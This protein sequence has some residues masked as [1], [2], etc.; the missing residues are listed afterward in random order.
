MTVTAPPRPS[1]PARP[2]DPQALIEEA[3]RRAR[4]RRRRTA[5]LLA[6]V[7]GAGIA[8]WLALGGGSIA[9]GSTAVPRRASATGPARNGPLTVIDSLGGPG[10]IYAVG[11]RGRGRRLFAGAPRP[12]F[13]HP[14][15]C[16]DIES[17]AWAPDGHRLALGC[18][19][20]GGPTSVDGLYIADAHTGTSRL[21]RPF[22]R[23]E[24]DW[25]DL[26]WSPDGST[27]AF[28]SRGEVA[29]VRGDGSGYRLLHTGTEGLD[30]A[31]TWSADGT[32]IA[33]ATS[34]GA[35]SVVFAV[36]L[37][38]SHR[39]LVATPG[40]WPA[41]SPDG[42]TIAY[43]APCG[44]RLATPWGKPLSG[45]LGVRAAP[46]WSPDGREIAMAVAGKGIYTMNADGSDLRLFTRVTSASVA[47]WVRKTWLR[48]AW[49]P[50]R[51]AG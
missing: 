42:G 46:V 47:S 1:Q 10:G 38:G 12:Y 15:R 11:P 29:L 5:A 2:V 43:L 19:S 9:G 16:I 33:Y 49:V 48:P 28:V 13:G 39:K 21:I 23:P 4:R 27:L 30:R 24:T 51:A 3:R 37:D 22:D 32:R 6:V 41:W 40:S 7:A 25:I 26:A 36:G 31:P 18:V 17:V 20:I 35:G 14:P 45:C 34:D 8:A 44:V 50:L